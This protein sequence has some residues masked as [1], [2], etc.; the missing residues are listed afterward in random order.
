MKQNKKI[1]LI[2][3]CLYILVCLVFVAPYVTYR[4]RQMRALHAQLSPFKEAALDYLEQDSEYD[5][6][7]P[8]RV[9]RIQTKGGEKN[10]FWDMFL[11]KA[12]MPKSYTDIYVYAKNFECKKEIHF[13]KQDDGEYIIIAVQ[14][15]PAQ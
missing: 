1:I 8:Y 2:I 3:L 10:S 15:L 13:Q 4:Q 11:Y 14:T 5:S 9:V 6:S 7:K 12:P